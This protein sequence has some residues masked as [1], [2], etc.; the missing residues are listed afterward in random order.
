MQ[1]LMLPYGI[2]G[3]MGALALTGG[4]AYGLAWSWFRVKTRQLRTSLETT[5][6]ESRSFGAR[7]AYTDG[8]RTL[9]EA[10]LSTLRGRHDRLKQELSARETEVGKLAREA[11]ALSEQSASR[12]Q[13][14]KDALDTLQEGKARTFIREWTGFYQ[15]IVKSFLDVPVQVQGH[16]RFARMLERHHFDITIDPKEEYPQSHQ[17]LPGSPVA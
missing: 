14:L 10:E 2:A 11:R 1:D 7:L 9:I 17:T 6:K 4:A 5:L 3:W 16:I 13:E 15:I 12:E 8:Q